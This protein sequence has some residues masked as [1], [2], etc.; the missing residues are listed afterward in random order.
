VSRGSQAAC[1]E[2]ADPAGGTADEDDLTHAAE[3]PFA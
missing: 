3:P 2:R 1:G